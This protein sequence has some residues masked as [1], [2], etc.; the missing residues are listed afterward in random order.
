M[1]G[2]H[3]FPQEGIQLPPHCINIFIP[4]VDLSVENGPTEFSPGTHFINRFDEDKIKFPMCANAGDAVLFDYRVKH[5]GMANLSPN[6]RLVLYMNYA[7]PFYRDAVNNRS[8]VPLMPH[9]KPWAPRVLRGDAIPL[10][11]SVEMDNVATQESASKR[12]KTGDHE[13]A[14]STETSEKEVPL[15]ASGEHWILFQMTVELGEVMLPTESTMS[16][17]HATMVF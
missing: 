9:S 16:Y 4:L 15:A 12:R 2:G 6:D 17:I 11:L 14:A 10:R 7:R 13:T 1:R 8:C 5:R 3:L